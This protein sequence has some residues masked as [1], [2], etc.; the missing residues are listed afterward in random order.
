MGTIYLIILD[1]LIS[2]LGVTDEIHNKREKL[3]DEL[4]RE[5]TGS[6]LTFVGAEVFLERPTHSRIMKTVS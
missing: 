3:N 1:G 6:G 5:S 2:M 4:W